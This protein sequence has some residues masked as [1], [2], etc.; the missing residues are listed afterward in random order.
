MAV[1]WQWCNMWHPDGELKIVLR[2]K[3]IAF[4]V[5]S[6]RFFP[7]CLSF[8]PF[9][10]ASPRRRLSVPRPALLFGCPSPT[11]RRAPLIPA[12]LLK[13]KRES[14][15]HHPLDLFHA[16]APTLLPDGA[17]FF[18]GSLWTP[19]V[20]QNG[21]APPPSSAARHPPA[22]SATRPCPEHAPFLIPPLQPAPFKSLTTCFLWPSS[23]TLLL[24]L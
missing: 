13:N 14:V 1:W 24:Q 8:L 22:L 7:S 11:G 18:P 6:R 12:A 23:R 16:P 4:T 15:R 20:L 17:A 9:P 5:G 10:S 19:R 2:C 3:L 21:R